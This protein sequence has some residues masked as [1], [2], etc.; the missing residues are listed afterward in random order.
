MHSMATL[1]NSQI[2]DDGLCFLQPLLAAGVVKGQASAVNVGDAGSVMLQA[3]VIERGTGGVA[4]NI[5]QSK[6]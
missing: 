1:L 6:K 3:C 5:G 4:F 2:A